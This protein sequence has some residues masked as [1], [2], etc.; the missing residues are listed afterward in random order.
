MYGTQA[1]DDYGST[2]GELGTQF[3]GEFFV[4]DEDTIRPEFLIIYENV[5]AN[6]LTMYPTDEGENARQVES[7]LS[8]LPPLD[9]VRSIIA[10][11]IGQS[12]AAALGFIVTTDEILAGSLEL[13]NATVA[14][15][16]EMTAIM[17]IEATIVFLYPMEFFARPDNKSDYRSFGLDVV[18]SKVRCV[19]VIVGVHKKRLKELKEPAYTVEEAERAGGLG[20]EERKSKVASMDE[21]TVA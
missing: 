3:E 18:L 9:F 20:R 15:S 8:D 13:T 16:L 5:E 11:H 21:D 7:E 10:S 19:I 4:N 12:A 1:S 17:T 6:T 2:Y 14:D